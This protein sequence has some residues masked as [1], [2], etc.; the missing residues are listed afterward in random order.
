MTGKENVYPRYPIAALGFSDS[1]YKLTV[2]FYSSVI[3]SSSIF[4]SVSKIA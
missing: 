4:I 1:R 3:N 2:L